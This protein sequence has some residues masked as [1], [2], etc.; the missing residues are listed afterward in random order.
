MLPMITCV[1][2]CEECH[3]EYTGTRFDDGVC[4]QCRRTL[5]LERIADVLEHWV[6]LL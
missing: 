4:V 1:R 3:G 6:G 5:A 2:D